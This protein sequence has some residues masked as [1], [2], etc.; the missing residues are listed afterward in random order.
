MSDLGKYFPHLTVSAAV[1]H[2][3]NDGTARARLK[4]WRASGDRGD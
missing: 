2:L 1:Y 4:E 3:G